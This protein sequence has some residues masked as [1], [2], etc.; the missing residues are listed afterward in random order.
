M[1]GPE[2][3]DI[4]RRSEGDDND[5]RKLAHY[6]GRLGATRSSANTVV[7][8]MIRVPSLRQISEIRTVDAP[9]SRDVTI[10]PENMSPY[11]IVRAIC[12]K[13]KFQNPIQIESAL[14]AIVDLD[15]PINDTNRVRATLSRGNLSL[16]YTLNCR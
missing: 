14:R 2:I 9:E 15:S 4:R 10:D 13:S 6:I 5:F 7:R 16:E 3:E 8:A 11:E 12:T 1:R